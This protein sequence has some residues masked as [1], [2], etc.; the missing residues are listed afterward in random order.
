LQSL[1]KKR[2]NSAVRSA[3]DNVKRSAGGNENVFPALLEAARARATVA[4]TMDAMA[5]VFGRHE[6]GGLS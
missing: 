3:L 6:T 2:D 1:K 4:E 5:E